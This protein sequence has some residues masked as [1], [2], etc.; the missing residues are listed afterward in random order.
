MRAREAMPDS[1]PPG[2]PSFPPRAV[3]G[4]IGGLIG[5]SAS[6]D[7]DDAAAADRADDDD[8]NNED[9]DDD[10]DDDESDDDSC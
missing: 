8:D 5:R 1:A 2:M 9:D 3:D 10:D 6:V 4:P 7:D